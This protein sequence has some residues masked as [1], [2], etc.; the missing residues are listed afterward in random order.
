MK[1]C[2]VARFGAPKQSG[3]YAAA[4][5]SRSS[6]VGSDREVIPVS[7]TQQEKGERFRALHDELDLRASQSMGC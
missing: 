5:G 1:P 6:M 4:G 3:S 7:A 2:L